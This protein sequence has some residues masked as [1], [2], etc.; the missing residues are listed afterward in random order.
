VA[1]QRVYGY[2]DGFNLYYGMKERGWR[3]TY[4]LDPY[5]LVQGM[6][7]GKPEPD[8]VKY[9][10]ARVKKPD[11]KRK[12]QTVYLDAIRAR[13]N[14]DVI[15]GK[16]SPRRMTCRQCGSSWNKP[17][18]KMTDSAIAAHLVADAFLDRFD[19]AILVGGDTDIIPA[20]K[21]VRLHFPNKTILAWYPP[22]RKNDAVGNLC[23]GSDMIQYQLLDDAQMPKTIQTEDGI[24]LNR[25]PEWS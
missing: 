13:G 1:G 15:L 20:I 16:F 8:A 12:R 17:E 3:R 7:K 11:A 24:E 21:L 25:P 23:H 4:W 14:S 10:T 6:L 22:K 9:F 5:S 19:T 18:E 2:V